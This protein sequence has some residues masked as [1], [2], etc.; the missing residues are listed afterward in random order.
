[1]AGNK[2]EKSS[3]VISEI[4]EEIDVLNAP[5]EWM[6][7][8]HSFCPRKSPLA[9]AFRVCGHLIGLGNDAQEEE[10]NDR[11]RCVWGLPSGDARFWRFRVSSISRLPFGKL[12]L[13]LCLSLQVRL[14]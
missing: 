7:T 5:F 6:R 9:D 2:K 8:A 1:M 14:R 3:E 10:A 12:T 11:R 13:S 4:A